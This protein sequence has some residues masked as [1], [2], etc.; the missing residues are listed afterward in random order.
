LREYL[1]KLRK[2]KSL[3]QQQMADKI[4][5]TKQYYSKIEKGERQRKMDLVLVSAI[6][7]IFDVP[8]EQIAEYEKELT[9]S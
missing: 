1:I 9:K 6:A 3:T 5:I 7:S 2:G 4:G 8:I